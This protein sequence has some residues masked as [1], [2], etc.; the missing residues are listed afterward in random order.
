MVSCKQISRLLYA[1]CATLY[2]ILGLVEFGFVDGFSKHA[3]KNSILLQVYVWIRLFL[4]LVQIPAHA[5]V[6]F[7]A[8]YYKQAADDL[9]NRIAPNMGDQTQI[10]N[11][12]YGYLTYCNIGM[13]VFILFGTV[14]LTY[15]WVGGY[16]ANGFY[17][18]ELCSIILLVIVL[19][20][21]IYGIF[22]NKTRQMFYL[23]N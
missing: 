4:A 20:A 7:S 15:S 14:V 10:Q 1:E 19:L 22:T 17:I 18:T 5:N 23:A 2:S 8:R 12:Y 9:L 11:K 6:L 16:S 21:R 13:S 3:T